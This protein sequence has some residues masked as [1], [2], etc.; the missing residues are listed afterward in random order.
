MA[1]LREQPPDGRLGAISCDEEGCVYRQITTDGGTYV[2][3][4]TPEANCVLQLRLRARDAKESGSDP[5]GE[6]GSAK[7]AQWE[8]NWTAEHQEGRPNY[9][10]NEFKWL[11]ER[12]PARSYNPIKDGPKLGVPVESGGDAGERPVV[13]RGSKY[14]IHIDNVTVVGNADTERRIRNLTDEQLHNFKKI[15]GG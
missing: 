4:E 7:R 14:E 5:F 6:R 10:Q 8:G 9:D 12:P 3:G 2:V 15:F 1:C 13:S 11:G